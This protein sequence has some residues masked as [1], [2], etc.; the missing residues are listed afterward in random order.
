MHLF[1]Y[2]SNAYAPKCRQF[3]P[4]ICL[5]TTVQESNLKRIAVNLTGVGYVLIGHL[6]K[7]ERK[8]WDNVLACWDQDTCQKSPCYGGC[9]HCRWNNK[10]LTDT[11]TSQPERRVQAISVVRALFQCIKSQTAWVFFSILILFPISF[12]LF[13]YSRG[14]HWYLLQL[15]LFHNR[16]R[17]TWKGRQIIRFTLDQ[18]SSRSTRAPSMI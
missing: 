5:N 9:Q 3:F 8:S 4:T 17:A 14:N 7:N 10:D 13:N 2:R 15:I 18:A 6:I 12:H 1:L 16:L 11:L